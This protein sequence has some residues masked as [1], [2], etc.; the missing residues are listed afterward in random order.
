MGPETS[1]AP[2]NNKAT[3]TK[4]RPANPTRSL[5]ILVS[6]LT[7]EKTGGVTSARPR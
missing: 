5:E 1:R 3:P 7:L 4:T 6:D 2:I